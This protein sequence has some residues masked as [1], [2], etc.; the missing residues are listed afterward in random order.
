MSSLWSSKPGHKDAEFEEANEAHGSRGCSREAFKNNHFSGT[1]GES[2]SSATQTTPKPAGTKKLTAMSG[3]RVCVYC[4]STL[5]GSVNK[6]DRLLNYLDALGLTHETLRPANYC[7][8]GCRLGYSL[9]LSRVPAIGIDPDYE[10]K[11]ALTAPTRLFNTTSDSFF[12]RD[13]VAQILGAPIDLAFIDGLHLVEFALRDFM[14][15]EKHASP[16]SVIVIDDLLPQHMDYASR[17]RNT[18]IWT[19]DVYRLIPILRHYR[20]D[21]DIRVYDVDMKG[22]GLVTRLDPSSNVLTANYGA[23]E[24]DILA[25]KWS[26]PTVA[27]IR[28]HMQPRATDL[29][30]NDLGIVAA[31]R[32]AKGSMQSDRRAAPALSQRRP[33][34]S[35]IICAYEMAR[36]APR[37]ILSATAPYQKGLRS[38]EYEVIVVDNGSSTP[39]TYDNLPPNVQIVRAPDPRQSPVFALNWA[40][41]E[42]AKGEI[43][44]FA[45]DGARIF[46][47]RLID[48]TVKAH[49]RMEDAFVFSL[50]WHIGPKVQMES[51]PEGYGAEIEDGLIRAARWPDEA[52]GLFGISVLA[53]SSSNGFFGDI[54]ESNSFS[55]SRTSFD[56]HGGFDERFTSPGGGLANLEIFRRYVTRPD[57]RN[58]C[59]LSEGTFHQVHDSVATSGKNRWEA[60]AGEYEAIFGGP[61]LRPSYHC[62]YQGKPRAGMVPF[63]L[64][65]LQG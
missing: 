21:L 11:V 26:F 12:A 16:D 23:I 52:D 48:E 53:G 60:F 57:A 10:I 18:T 34:L 15:L 39:L 36:E 41:R 28:D 25:G 29:L 46:S 43:L 14:N 55:I 20:P 8:I 42:I 3:W 33:R 54:T 51:V 56:R 50:A 65:S 61:Y 44:L 13:D 37:T 49:D 58:V 59:L 47:E 38:D 64:Q 2:G 63:I 30:A 22:F 27:A 9:A 31:Q 7:E 45:I 5:A 24:A 19:G 1:I 4:A 6:E 35:V 32:A 17:Q 62:F 40:A